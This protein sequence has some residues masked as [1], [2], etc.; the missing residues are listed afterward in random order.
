[1]VVRLCA[2]SE[3]WLQGEAAKEWATA[4][5]ASVGCVGRTCLPIFS[6]FSVL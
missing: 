1:M 3:E 5:S 2:G 4:R 6:D